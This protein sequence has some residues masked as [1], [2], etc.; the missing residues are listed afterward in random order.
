MDCLK[1]TIASIYF[2]VD[3]IYVGLNNYKKIPAFLD[4]NKIEPFL[5]DNK[6]GDAEKFRYVGKDK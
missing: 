3:K 5:S 2:Q 6:L 1:K 4:E